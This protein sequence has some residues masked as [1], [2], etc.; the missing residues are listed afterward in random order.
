VQERL[1]HSDVETTMFHT[2]VPIKADHGVVS[3]L[4]AR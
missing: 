1:G 4:D 2:S 3:P